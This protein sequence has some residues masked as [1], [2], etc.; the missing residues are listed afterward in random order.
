MGFFFYDAMGLNA[1]F[2]WKAS[3]TL[4]RRM[5]KIEGYKPRGKIIDNTHK[6]VKSEESRSSTI[7]YSIDTQKYQW[8]LGNPGIGVIL[9]P[10]FLMRKSVPVRMS[11]S[12]PSLDR[13]ISGD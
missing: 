4:F 3:T 6:K 12:R 10:L 7:F 8:L 13:I 11:G 1:R 2:V 9:F 5:D